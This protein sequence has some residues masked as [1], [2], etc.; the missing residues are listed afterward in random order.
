MA[1]RAKQAGKRESK[2]FSSLAWHLVSFVQQL[3]EDNLFQTQQQNALPSPIQLCLF[4]SRPLT[5]FLLEI[6][7]VCFTNRTRQ[8]NGPVHFLFISHRP[9]FVPASRSVPTTTHIST[10]ASTGWTPKSVPPSKPSI[11]KKRNMKTCRI[12]ASRAP[13]RSDPGLVLFFFLRASCCGQRKTSLTSL[14]R[15]PTNITH[16][17]HSPLP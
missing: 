9:T 13:P 6:L 5:L 10:T 1:G 2:T 11:A 4:Q 7:L 12:D 3:L 14:S 8:M 17:L 16:S 15:V